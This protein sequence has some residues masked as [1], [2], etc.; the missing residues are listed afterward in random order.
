MNDCSDSSVCDAWRTLRLLFKA[1]PW[2][3]IPIGSETPNIVNAYVEMV[4]TDVVKYEVDK[5]SGYLRVDRPQKYSS[6]SPS[7]Y[8]FVPQ[9]YCGKRIGEYTSTMTGRPGIKGDGD[10]IDICILTERPIQHSGI[11]LKA[12]PIGGICMLDGAQA[13]DKIIAVLQDDGVYG[14]WRDLSECPNNLLDRLQ[15]YFLTYKDLPGGQ[16]RR[17]EITNS[18]GV[19]EARTLIQLSHQD[20]LESFKTTADLFTAIH[21]S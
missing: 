12:L 3:G 7:L 6:Q 8:G 17:V 13:D 9:T 1:H 14:S 20:Y 21:T 18:Y 11:I 19:E 16:K 5:D 2:H 4:P 10:P 15:H